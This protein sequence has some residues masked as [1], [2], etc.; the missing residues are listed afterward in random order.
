MEEIITTR[1]KNKTIP[2]FSSEL[3]YVVFLIGPTGPIVAPVNVH[4]LQLSSLHVLS[5]QVQRTHYPE[6]KYNNMYK[7]MQNDAATQNV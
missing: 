6:P 5:H 3:K 1:L 7:T 4:K 2:N